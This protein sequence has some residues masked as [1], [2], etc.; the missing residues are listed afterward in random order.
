[1]TSADWQTDISI[2][3]V[4]SNCTANESRTI[5]GVYFNCLCWAF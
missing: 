1:M 3:P 4:F 5:L 2:N